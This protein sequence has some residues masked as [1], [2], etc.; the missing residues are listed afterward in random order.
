MLEVVFG[1]GLWRETER[2]WT[3][4]ESACLILEV[5]TNPLAW[6]LL[7]IFHGPCGLGVAN[8]P[9]QLPGGHLIQAEQMCW[10]WQLAQRLACDFS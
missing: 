9:L 1:V 7:S 10:P 4:T 6:D 8:A 5:A 3:V 2:G